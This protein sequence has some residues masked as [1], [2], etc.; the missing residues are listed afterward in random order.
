MTT[1]TS[2]TQATFVRTKLFKRI[3]HFLTRTTL[4]MLLVIGNIGVGKSRCVRAAL[5]EAD[6]PTCW[7]PVFR[8]IDLDQLFGHYTKIGDNIVFQ[9]G[10]LMDAIKTP[11]CVIILDDCHSIADTDSLQL[12]NPIGDPGD[13]VRKLVC[14]ML[15]KDVEIA[16]NVRIILIANEPSEGTPQWER[17]RSEIPSQLRDRS[18]VLD[19]REGL[20]QAEQLSIAKKYW[21]A[22]SPRHEMENVVELV[23]HL[24]DSGFTTYTPSLRALLQIA[25]LRR[26]D[27]SLEDAFMSAVASKYSDSGERSAALAA[28]DA[29]FNEDLTEAE[30]V[31]K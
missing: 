2:I 11:D 14:S 27:L 19:V 18:V 21:P 26:A 16:E 24:Q 20:S 3:L 23:A 1:T 28:Y 13:P 15:G 10:L 30:V 31:K 7:I 22:S 5:A 29:K 4:P 9:P 25:E 6:C 17:Y 8:T 12:L